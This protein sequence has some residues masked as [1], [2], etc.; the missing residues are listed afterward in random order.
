[1]DSVL[2]VLSRRERL[3]RSETVDNA[4]TTEAELGE[5]RLVR[6]RGLESEAEVV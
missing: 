5:D 3:P 1:M 4:G 6:P 2:A